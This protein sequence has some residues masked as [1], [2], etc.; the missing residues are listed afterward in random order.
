MRK[1]LIVTRNFPPAIGGIESLCLQLSREL[2]AHGIDLTVIAPSAEGDVAFDVNERYRVVRIGS[3]VPRWLGESLC[4]A[5]ELRR[6]R[7]SPYDAVLCMQWTAAVV[8]TAHKLAR[9]APNTLAIVGHGKEYLAESSSSAP[10]PL[11]HWVRKRVLAQ[12]THFFPVSTGTAALAR[13]H[14]GVERAYVLNPGVDTARFSPVPRELVQRVR[15][16][17]PGPFLLTVARLVPR[18]GID[19]VIRALPEI[20]R[21]H[22]K[23][24]YWVVGDGS[25]RARLEALAHELG[26]SDRVELRGA[27]APEEVIALYSAADLF[28]LASRAE[29]ADVEG[30][31]LVL[32]EAQACGTAVLGGAA[33]GVPDAF[34]AG[35]TG[36]LVDP[37]DP[38]DVARAACELFDDPERRTRM[39]S[40]ALTYART[41]SWRDVAGRMLAALQKP[42][43]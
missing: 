43:L 9:R 28:V 10:E 12:A 30:F 11:R 21:R 20:A 14:A 26:V 16:E 8:V 42:K 2:V 23:V 38:R 39:A 32:L 5:R 25:D 35:E 34:V 36:L 37:E 1:L 40:A 33:G 18:K 22:P 13:Q 7:L 19:T 17:E 27:I 3:D 15:G 41:Q 29:G 31:G 4:V 24:R 6:S